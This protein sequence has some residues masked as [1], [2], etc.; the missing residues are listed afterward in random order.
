MTDQGPT[1]S[2][3]YSHAVLGGEVL[4]YDRIGSTNTAL[5]EMASKGAVEGTV[6]VANEQLAGRGRFDRTWNS[7]P[8]AGFYGSILVR[9]RSLPLREAQTLT[10]VAAI[11]VAEALQSLGAKDVAIKWPNDVLAGGKK[12]CGILTESG[13]VEDHVEWAV[14]GIGVNLR[15]ENVPVELLDRATSLEDEGLHVSS[16]TLLSPLLAAFDRWYGTLL[17]RGAEA[18][19]ERWSELA[20]MAH[21]TRVSVDDGREV[22]EAT[23]AGVS[24]DGLLRVRRDGGPVEEVTAADVFLK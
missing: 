13:C 9:P 3:S 16:L 1:S 2:L 15:H 21:D 11:A 17:E 19:I 14:V 8:G 20:P 10:F 24:P 5:R 18:V 22:F 6:V 4:V 7:P 12:V 23:T